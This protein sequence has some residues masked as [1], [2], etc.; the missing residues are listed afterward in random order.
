M[1]NTNITE[2]FKF[3]IQDNPKRVEESLKS[4]SDIIAIQFYSIECDWTN[5]I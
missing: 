5:Q 4:W 2:F 3:W 1:I